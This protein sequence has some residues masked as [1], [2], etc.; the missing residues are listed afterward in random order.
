[1]MRRPAAT[2]QCEVVAGCCIVRRERAKQA[3][4]GGRGSMA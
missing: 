4:A 3:G 1:M 2:P